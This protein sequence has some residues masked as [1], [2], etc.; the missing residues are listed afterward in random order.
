MPNPRTTLILSII[1]L[2]YS[3]ACAGMYESFEDRARQK[4]SEQEAE[5]HDAK[6]A[7][8]GEAALA[9]IIQSLCAEQKNYYLHDKAVER[10][11]RIGLPAIRALFRKQRGMTEDSLCEGYGD[12]RLDDAVA[13]VYCNAERF[14]KHGDE[15]QESIG[16][17]R[18][19]A[20]ENPDEL[21]SIISAIALQRRNSG[22][23]RFES[24]AEEF[25]PLI[26][27]IL[28]G[29]EAKMGQDARDAR[30]YALNVVAGLGPVAG[31]LVKDILPY[32]RDPNLDGPA[33][34]ALEKIG[35]EAS[36]AVN[37]LRAALK[38][39]AATAKKIAFVK[40]LGEMGPPAM[41][42]ALPDIKRLVERLLDNACDG[43][44]GRHLETAIIVL[45]KLAR[46]SD[47]FAARFFKW[48]TGCSDRAIA[49][50]LKTALS[51]AHRC[52]SMPVASICRSIASLGPSGAPASEELMAF[53]RDNRENIETRG[54]AARALDVLGSGAKLTPADKKIVE[55]ILDRSRPQPVPQVTGPYEGG[56][57]DSSTVLPR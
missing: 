40:A 48:R 54:A 25:L 22:C 2:S 11:E 36:M 23:V 14:A 9:E 55:E 12:S 21:L 7:A 13:C 50:A 20:E 1:A 32:L 42:A 30:A 33:A 43:R 28:R 53:V 10:L 27:S 16:L 6:W 4:A 47:D 24:L 51:S 35:P 56:I 52:L 29:D 39:N 15:W 45:C 46:S 38:S 18:K 5:K 17:L 49:E 57:P 37:D 26:S 19:K 31:P 3:L 8:Q 44:N 34:E 41:R